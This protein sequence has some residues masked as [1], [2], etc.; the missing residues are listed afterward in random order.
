MTSLEC[1]RYECRAPWSGVQY[2]GA[3][4]MRRFAGCAFFICIIACSASRQDEQRPEATASQASALSA[5]VTSA[6]GGSLR[7]RPDGAARPG[8]IAAATPASAGACSEDVALRGSPG[9]VIPQAKIQFAY[10]GSYWAGAGQ[11][12]RTA[13]D[14]A[15]NDVGNNAAFY[16]RLAEYSTATQTIGAGT[17]I[18]STPAD[19]YLAGWGMV[20][21]V[22][23]HAK[24]LAGSNSAPADARI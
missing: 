23:I 21:Q 22:Q 24:V 7:E 11:G 1:S 8:A 3:H 4:A 13:Y 2:E 18:C 17:W 9:T 16:A 14:Q 20:T 6:R 5:R 15:W 10:W 12:E 19:R